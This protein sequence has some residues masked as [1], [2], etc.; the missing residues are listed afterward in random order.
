MVS[1]LKSQQFLNWQRNSLLLWNPAV[2]HM[3]T[4]V[5]FW[6]LSWDCIAIATV[7]VLSH[8]TRRTVFWHHNFYWSR[9]I[10]LTAFGDD[11]DHVDHLENYWN[12]I[13]KTNIFT[14]LLNGYSVLLPVFQLLLVFILHGDMGQGKEK[15][16][17]LQFY[18][19]LQCIEDFSTKSW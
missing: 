12:W 9:P 10:E 5:I 11:N 7:K 13:S 2:H 15:K 17:R 1:S 8:E 6:A 19:I 14:W 18:E 16:R 4:K 3:F